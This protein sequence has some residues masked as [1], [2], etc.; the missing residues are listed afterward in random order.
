P[1]AF[2]YS[3]GYR[4]YGKNGIR[5]RTIMA[6]E[7][8]TR[9][10]YFSNPDITASETGVGVPVGIAAGHTGESNNALTLQKTSFE[11]ASFRKQMVTPF[12]T[13]RMMGLATR[14]YVGPGE[15]QLIGGIAV[16]GRKQII[17]RASGPSL[18]LQGVSGVLANPKITLNRLVTN[19]GVV[20]SNDDWGTLSNKAAFLAASRQLGL[21][22]LSS[23]LESALMLTLDGGL[24]T[25]NIE[26]SDGGTGVAL[27]EAYEV[28]DTGDL[29]LTGIATRGYADVNGRE[30]IAGLNVEGIAGQTKRIIVRVKGPS[31]SQQG[32]TTAMNDPMLEL[33]AL[34][35]SLLLTNDDWTSGAQV[36]NGVGDD[37]QPTATYYHETEISN[38]GFA[39][40]NRREPAIMVDL[41]PGIYTVVVKPFERLDSDPALS[42]PAE[43]GVVLV[44]VYELAANGKVN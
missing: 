27:M 17:L 9:L 25:S 21:T 5:Y 2:S 26:G 11:V 15:Q 40:T 20:D 33:H 38:T 14:A 10:N 41:L 37:F 18:L 35:G 32:I 1:G 6:Y 24:Y 29:K 30:M 7:P 8:G 34:D 22:D 43:P 39:P 42:Q 44:E 12:Y 28:T 4:F 36:V 3:Y 31:L 19:V 13:G 16:S 23:S